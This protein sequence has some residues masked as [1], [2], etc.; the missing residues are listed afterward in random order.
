MKLLLVDDDEMERAA[1]RDVLRAQGA[2]DIVEAGDGQQAFD[3]LCD[4]LEP[5]VC[6]FDLRMPKLDGKQLLSMLRQEQ[7]LRHLKVV[8]TSST[9]DREVVLTVG[10]LGISGYL[11]KPY[12]MEKTV[13]SLKQIFGDANFLGNAQGTRNLLGK[14]ILIVDDDPMTRAALRAMIDAG[15]NWEIVEADDGLAALDQLRNGLRPDL[16]ITDLRMPKLDG[17]NLVTRIR[18]TPALRYIPVLVVSGQQDRERIKAL[19]QLRISGYL[20]KPFSF[21]KVRASINQTLGAFTPNASGEPSPLPK[22]A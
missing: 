12:A 4:G 3:L 16:L 17:H 6:F 15:P 10:K 20:L 7:S 19:V 8:M 18:E 13:A 2:A 1:L 22:S 14:T 21:E 11:L 9:T 5:E